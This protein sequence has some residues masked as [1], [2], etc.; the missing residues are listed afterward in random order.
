M[1]H[2]VS[3][4]VS[5][6]N[7]APYLAAM[8]ESLRAQTGNFEREFIFID[9]GSKD[10]SAAVLAA[11][12]PSL[13]GR[14]VVET[15]KNG[16]QA[17]ATNRGFTYVTQDFVKLVD[18]DDLVHADFTQVMLDAMQADPA[19]AMAISRL[20]QF[21]TGAEPDVA[22]AWTLQGVVDRIANPAAKMLRHSF[23][24]PTQLLVR[25]SALKACG[26]CDERVKHCIDHGLGLRLTQHGAFL[27]VPALL[28]FQRIGMNES[29]S[30]S[31]K[32][33]LY[34]VTAHSMWFLRDYPNV[35]DDLK[36][37]AVK[38]AAGRAW[39]WRLRHHNDHALS[40][41]SL[42]RLRA[43]LPMRNHADFIESLLPAFKPDTY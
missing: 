24:N 9:D 12:T 31:V 23:F 20:E 1:A 8:I 36:F 29:L 35:S 27:D 6:Y 15:I 5:V 11:L 30:A 33:M 2:G 17:V 7:K 34:E 37:L 3:Y 13:P 38:R 19:A 25:T 32:L 41:W 40:R 10:D 26:G 42:A 4:V 43:Y 21:K 28:A 14:V 22:Q 16:G 39:L 18:A